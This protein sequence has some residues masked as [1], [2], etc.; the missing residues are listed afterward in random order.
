MGGRIILKWTLKK[1]TVMRLWDHMAESDV[2][3][4]VSVLAELK[5][6]IQTPQNKSVGMFLI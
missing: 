3:C 5:H 6:H 1:L 2:L 4:L